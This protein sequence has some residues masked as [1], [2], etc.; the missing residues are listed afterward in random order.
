MNFFSA[1]MSLKK[2]KHCMKNEVDARFFFMNYGFKSQAGA[3]NQIRH[4]YA[5]KCVQ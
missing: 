2:Q 3:A 5:W 1:K 4:T